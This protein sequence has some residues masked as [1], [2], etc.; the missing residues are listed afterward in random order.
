MNLMSKE[1]V[2]FRPLAIFL[3]LACAA[4]PPCALGAGNDDEPKQ[5]Q[6]RLDDSRQDAEAGAAPAKPSVADKLD[7]WFFLNRNNPRIAASIITIGAAFGAA[8][9]W[10]HEWDRGLLSENPEAEGIV[11]GAILWG[12]F[13]VIPAMPFMRNLNPL[14]AAAKRNL[15]K[16]PLWRPLMEAQEADDAEAE[17]V[18]EEQARRILAGDPRPA[19][20]EPEGEQGGNCQD[21]FKP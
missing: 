20:K 14:D 8:M 13:S 16:D 9:G 2:F 17:R 1:P 12:L 4:F 21:N 3:L 19:T 15:K 6:E 7:A 5:N 18:R 10:P 11:T